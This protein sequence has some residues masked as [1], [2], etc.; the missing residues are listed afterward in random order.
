MLV[1]PNPKAVAA[2]DSVIGTTLGG[3][4][5]S[6]VYHNYNSK[7]IIELYRKYYNKLVIRL[8]I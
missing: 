7:Y 3:I 4:L 5:L 1:L 8:G 2:I 6:I